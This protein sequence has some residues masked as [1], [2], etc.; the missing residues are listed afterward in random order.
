[1]H[2][3]VNDRATLAMRYRFLGPSNVGVL[4]L[5]GNNN[6]NLVNTPGYMDADR[7]WDTVADGDYYRDVW[8]PLVGD[9][10]WRTTYAR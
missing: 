5:R 6:P 1:M 2:L 9:G 7:S 10:E 3:S 4:K 8:F